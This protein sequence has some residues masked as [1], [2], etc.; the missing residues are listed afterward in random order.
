VTN[1]NVNSLAGLAATGL[2]GLG[3]NTLTWIINPVTSGNFLA[4]LSGNGSNALSDAS[5]TPLLGGAGYNR[6]FSVLFGDFN[7]DGVVSAGDLAGVN[8][9]TA[10]A[11]NPFAD[12]NGDGIVNVSDVQ[13]VRTRIGTSLP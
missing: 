10:T 1:G 6:N 13:L 3:T 4:S 7:D 8:N 9:A 11:Y 12:M 5:G 2:T